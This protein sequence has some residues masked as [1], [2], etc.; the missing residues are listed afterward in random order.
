MRLPCIPLISL[1]STGLPSNTNDNRSETSV[2]GCGA[3]AIW[4]SN[5]VGSVISTSSSA[6]T[7]RFMAPMPTGRASAT[8]APRRAAL[9]PVGQRLIFSRCPALRIPRRLCRNHFPVSDPPAYTR[10]DYVSDRQWDAGSRW[11]GPARDGIVADHTRAGDVRHT[12]LSVC[13]RR[14]A[15]D[16]VCAIR[17]EVPGCRIVALD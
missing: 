14:R 15:V 3:T 11:D 6:P 2:F 7:S 10:A 8:K 4:N 5:V 13:P 9:Y 16:W 12:Y 1:G 17:V